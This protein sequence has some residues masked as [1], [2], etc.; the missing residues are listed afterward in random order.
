VPSTHKKSIMEII[1]VNLAFRAHQ[2]GPFFVISGEVEVLAAH[3][4]ELPDK[5][6]ES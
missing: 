5:G 2:I 4:R 6:A 1:I 3:A